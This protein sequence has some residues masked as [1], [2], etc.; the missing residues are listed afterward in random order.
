MSG[1]ANSKIGG[2]V[3]ELESDDTSDHWHT[4]TSGTDQE[5]GNDRYV[6]GITG[7]TSQQLKAGLPAGFDPSIRAVDKTINNGFPYGIANPPAKT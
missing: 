4:T 2:F 1:S 7:Q 6:S 3:G 5:T